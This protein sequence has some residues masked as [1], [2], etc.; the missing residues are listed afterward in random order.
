MELFKYLW[1]IFNNVYEIVLC[2]F[3][4]ELWIILDICWNCIV[5]FCVKLLM[6]VFDYIMVV[7]FGIF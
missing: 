4:V 3:V 1:V 5:C 6:N 7:C 2:N